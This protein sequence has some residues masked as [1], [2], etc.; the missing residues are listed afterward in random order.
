MLLSTTT[1]TVTAKTAVASAA[2]A[3]VTPEAAASAMARAA[4]LMKDGKYVE[5]RAVLNTPYLESRREQAAKLRDML[6]QINKELVFNPRNVEGATV[7]VVKAKERLT[8]IARLYHV[9]WRSL[10]TLNG[11]SGDRLRLGQK[12]KVISGPASAVAY[13]SEFRLALLLNGV[14]VKEYPIGIGKE[15]SETPKGA[16]TVSIMQEK[17]TWYKPSGGVVGYGEEGN[18]L[19]ER[20]IGFENQPGATGIGIH[21]TNDET[22]I[23]TKCS[24]GCIRMHNA[25]VVELYDFLHPGSRVE[26]RD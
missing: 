23:K 8:T 7:H 6:D 9:N 24:N 2:S 14:Y 13:K 21:G 25:D 3:S 4:A 15:G 26:I 16:F 1:T 19:G 10:Q 22:T 5:A 12:L 20:W 17:P 18:M 11:M